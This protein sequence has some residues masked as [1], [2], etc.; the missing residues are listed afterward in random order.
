MPLARWAW[1]SSETAAARAA[2]LRG[3]SS[4][5]PPSKNGTSSCGSLSVSCAR[6]RSKGCWSRLWLARRGCR[7]NARRAAMLAGGLEPVARAA[8]VEG[9]QGSARFTLTLFR[10]I[11]PMLADSAEGVGDALSNLGDAY[12]GDRSTTGFRSTDRDRVKVFTAISAEVTTMPESSRP[13]AQCP[14]ASSCWTA[15]RSPFGPTGRRS[16]FES[17]DE[18]CRATSSSVERDAP[19]TGA[20]LPSSRLPLR[21]WRKKVDG[22]EAALPS[23][24]TPSPG[25]APP[26]RY[27]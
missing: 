11:Q 3:S 27:G 9:D 19:G 14:P 21:R 5:A 17:N 13:R 4:T 25:V 23:G 1:C 12:R 7:R 6:G 8:L 20:P 10:P 18:A 2:L 26:P 24:W 16:H 15:R 22:E